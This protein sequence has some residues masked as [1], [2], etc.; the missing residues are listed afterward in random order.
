MATLATV[1]NRVVGAKAETA[2]RSNEAAAA[3]KEFAVRAIPNEDIYLFVKDIDN[4]RVVRQADPRARVACWRYIVSGG[5]TVMLL[6]GVL[7]PSAASRIAGYQVE[8]LRQE[9]QKLLSE[10]A[11]LELEEARLL[12]PERLEEIARM[13]HFV[14]P[15]P[16]K[17]VYLDGKTGAL[18]LNVKK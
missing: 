8:S 6:I 14:D 9:Q 3:S 17:V 10:K 2:A 1:Y 12:S 5:V 18:A 4:A 15:A 13:Q 16:A 7:L 11:N